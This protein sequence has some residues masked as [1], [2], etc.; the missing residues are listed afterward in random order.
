LP[1][2]RLLFLP[3]LMF[4]IAY[5]G[6]NFGVRSALIPAV[7]SALLRSA[8]FSITLWMY[9]FDLMRDERLVI[10]VHVMSVLVVIMSLGF[11]V[12]GKE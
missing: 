4:Y 12:P 10:A 1:V 11:P 2:G 6:M 5:N 8:L 7:S 3:V 9:P